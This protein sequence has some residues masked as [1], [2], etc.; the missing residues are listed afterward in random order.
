MQSKVLQ[1]KYIIHF[2]NQC[3]NKNTLPFWET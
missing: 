2:E 1:Q 3:K